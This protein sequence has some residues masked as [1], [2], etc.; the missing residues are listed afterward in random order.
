MVFFYCFGGDRPQR[1]SVLGDNCYKEK[2]A[3]KQEKFH[4]RINYDISN[5]NIIATSCITKFTT[6]N[7]NKCD[8]RR[9]KNFNGLSP[10]K[11]DKLIDFYLLIGWLIDWLIKHVG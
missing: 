9:K 6:N 7:K 1:N 10:P 3:A 4:W 8:G 11:H 5:I 2:Y